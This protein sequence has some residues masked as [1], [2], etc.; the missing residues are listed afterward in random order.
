[1]RLTNVRHIILGVSQLKSIHVSQLSYGFKGTRDRY[2]LQ[3]LYHNSSARRNITMAS[4]Q[5]SDK[6]DTLYPKIT[7]SVKDL[8]RNLSHQHNRD[9]EIAIPTTIPLTGTV[10]LHGMHADIVIDSNNEIRLQ[11]R[12]VRSLNLSNDIQGFAARMLPLREEI[13]KLKS[14]IHARFLELNTDLAINPEHP[15]IIAGEWVSPN[16]AEFSIVSSLPTTQSRV[17]PRSTPI[18]PNILSLI[19]N[20]IN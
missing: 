19:M 9:P 7:G 11:S 20:A 3:I 18:T 5:D 4:I 13:L 10:K 8:I 14:R 16:F 17:V 6:P 2:A 15:L 1:M 12:N